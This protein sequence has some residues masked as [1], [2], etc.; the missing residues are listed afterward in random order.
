MID[1]K[2]YGVI[3][4]LEDGKLV[5]HRV[6]VKKPK[7]LPEPKAYVH[8][9]PL[10]DASGVFTKEGIENLIVNADKLVKSSKRI[11]AN[12]QIAEYYEHYYKTYDIESHKPSS[13]ASCLRFFD[14]DY[15]IKQGYKDIKRVNLCKDKFC[16]NCQAQLSQHR[17][18]KYAPI[19]D[20]Y[21]KD[22]K[23]FHI[24]FTVP[25]CIGAA[26]KSTLNKMT[27]C[28]AKLIRYFQGKKIKDV[29]LTSCG[30]VG[31][32]KAFE[33]VVNEEG[34]LADFHPHYHCLFVFKHSPDTGG[35]HQN[36][37]S[38]KKS[39]LKR[40][41]KLKDD[42]NSKQKI[43]FFS[44]FEILLQKIWYLLYNDK[45]VTKANID[46][47]D[48]GYSCYAQRVA[49][50]YKEVFKYSMK[51]LYDSKK[52]TFLYSQQT[53]NYLFEAL[54][55]RKMIQ[56]YG[57]LNKFNFMDDVEIEELNEYYYQRI[58]ALRNIEDPVT[59]HSTLE[60]LVK[61]I[62]GATDIKYIS[63]NSLYTMYLKER[64]KNIEL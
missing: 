31:A 33:I 5:S 8:K 36:I 57:A 2:H 23:I 48:L 9:D 6:Y 21:L 51:G 18:A 39:E 4:R 1:E 62:T 28:F 64:G 19:L 43:R 47:L 7:P 17:Y 42:V 41:R 20:D 14:I 15:F 30:F 38:F 11:N 49:G 29:D 60:E 32:I 56:G 58:I 40:D 52:G 26:L 55:R 27:A 45:T 37:Y 13:V 3:T 61:E 12:R 46:A 34:F 35:R 50:N 24:V 63:K 44:D 54:Y 10:S 22:Y 16:L 25:N 53:F 59:L